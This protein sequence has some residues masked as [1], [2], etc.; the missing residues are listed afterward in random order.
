MSAGRV[1]Y[2]FLEKLKGF[3]FK[4]RVNYSRPASSPDNYWV[5]KNLFRCMYVEKFQK[6]LAG[7]HPFDQQVY[8]N[9]KGTLKNELNK[10][11]HLLSHVLFYSSIQTFQPSAGIK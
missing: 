3:F 7:L 11:T 9:R 4:A 5:V 10:K 1:N 2:T 6:V 8:Q